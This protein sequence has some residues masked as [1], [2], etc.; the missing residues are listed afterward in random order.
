LTESWSRHGIEFVTSE[1]PTGARLTFWLADWDIS[2]GEYFFNGMAQY[3][4]GL[5]VQVSLNI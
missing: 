5:M 1:N 2:G 3:F 4:R